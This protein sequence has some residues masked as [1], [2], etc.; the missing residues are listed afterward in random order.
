MSTTV[1][2]ADDHD[3]VRTGIRRLLEDAGYT[4]VAE[5]ATGEEAVELV[6]EH[7]P[8]VALIDIHMPGIGGFEATQKIQ[9][10]HPQCRVIILTAH[11]DGPL[12][13][14]LLEIGVD[15]FLSKGCSVEEMT[16]AIS[17]VQRGERYLSRDV[18]QK[19]ALA[20]VDG[21]RRSP[22]DHLTARELQVTLRMLAGEPN[23]DIS[24]S[25]NLSPKTITTYRQRIMSKTG[26]RTLTEL[27]RLAIEFDLVSPDRMPGAVAPG[28]EGLDADEPEQE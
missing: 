9:R 3:L 27:L 18:A 28:A 19:L 20:A 26:V 14:T 10:H 8:D 7:Q 11:L 1:L 15:G 24:A 22:F 2:I 5:A 12:P 17:R 21:E 6:R 25:L 4:V 23:R 16:D 13:R